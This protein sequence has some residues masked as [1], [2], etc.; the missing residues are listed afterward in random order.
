M[1]FEVPLSIISESLFEKT[2]VN[3]SQIRSEPAGIFD[4]GTRVRRCH[5]CLRV[6]ECVVEDE[7]C[8]VVVLVKSSA[9]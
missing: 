6:V 5:F 2:P 7:T 3:E 4:I 8:V 1:N 9:E